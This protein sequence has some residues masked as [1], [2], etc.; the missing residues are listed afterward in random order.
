MPSK[1]IKD[2][3]TVSKPPKKWSD[4]EAIIKINSDS[5]GSSEL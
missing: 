1:Y 5:M 2:P 3:P 4:L